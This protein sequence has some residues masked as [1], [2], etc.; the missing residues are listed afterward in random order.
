MSL[1]AQTRRSDEAHPRG[2]THTL[3]LR[4]TDENVSSELRYMY[5]VLVLAIA[6]A[7]PAVCLHMERKHF[8][9]RLLRAPRREVWGSAETLYISGLSSHPSVDDTVESRKSE[10]NAQTEPHPR[11]Q[12]RENAVLTSILPDREVSSVND[13]NADKALIGKQ[14]RQSLAGTGAR[15]AL[16]IVGHARSFHQPSVRESIYRNLI[17]SLS[18]NSSSL[19]VIFHIGLHDVA[20]VPGMAATDSEKETISAAEAMKPIVISVYE[21]SPHLLNQSLHAVCSEGSDYASNE[22]PPSLLRAS[23]CM[24]L[25]KAR[26]RQLG[27]KYDWIVK[28]RPDVAFGDPVSISHLPSDRVYINEHIPGTSTPAFDTIRELYPNNAAKYLAK[29]F[30]DHIAA[31]PR[32]LADTF[33]LSHLAAGECLTPLQRQRLVNPETIMG[34]WLMRSGVRYQTLPWLWIL[35]RDKQGPECSRVQWV[36]RFTGQTADFTRRCNEYAKTGTIPI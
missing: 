30:A 13:N 32:D 14:I 7:V 6:F 1:G 3:G 8:R 35:V 4:T 27:T 20:R 21:G 2:I 5:K 22:Y 25:V 9:S 18:A 16:C 24:T 23:Q 29:P 36:G 31:V 19:E 10:I 26:E 12:Q 17:Q 15:I 33:F 11:Q 28:T 34:M